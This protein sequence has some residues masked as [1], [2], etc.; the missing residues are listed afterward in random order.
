LYASVNARLLAAGADRITTYDEL[1]AI[2]REHFNETP[3]GW[4]LA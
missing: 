1:L 3:A 2:L 4:D